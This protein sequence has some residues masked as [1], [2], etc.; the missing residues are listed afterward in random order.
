MSSSRAILA[1]AALIAL[2]VLA[3]DVVRP[4]VAQY[5]QPGPFSL[6]PN[7]NPNANSSIFRINN[8]T[9]EV[10]YCYV[11]GGNGG[12]SVVCTGYVR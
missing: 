1:G 9:G 5:V 11:P 3:H 2:S 8:A 7:N 12:T 6:M 10:G 4:A